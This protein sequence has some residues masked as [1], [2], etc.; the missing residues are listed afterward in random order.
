MVVWISI[1]EVIWQNI[2]FYFVKSFSKLFND[3]RLFH[4]KYSSLFKLNQLYL[5]LDFSNKER[6][7]L[8]LCYHKFY[9][10]KYCQYWRAI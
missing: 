1:T 2:F 4:S 6:Y 3:F 5:R 8:M 9:Y 7:S 10:T